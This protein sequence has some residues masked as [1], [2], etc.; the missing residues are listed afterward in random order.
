MLFYVNLDVYTLCLTPRIHP[1]VSLCAK[2]YSNAFDT[3][4]G[5]SVKSETHLPCCERYAEGKK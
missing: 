2:I 3:A 1:K 4:H 5:G